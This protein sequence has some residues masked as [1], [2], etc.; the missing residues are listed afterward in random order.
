MIVIEMDFC[1]DLEG[2]GKMTDGVKRKYFVEPQIVAGGDHADGGSEDKEA[3]AK[4][5]G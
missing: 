4:A 3:E 5:K 2:G 1:E